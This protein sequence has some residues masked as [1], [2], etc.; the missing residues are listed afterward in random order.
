MSER[1]KILLVDDEQNILN[2]L[3]RSF[4]IK[5]YELFTAMNA[6]DALK[7]LEEQRIDLIVTDY[8]MPE[9]NG[10]ELLR[11]V[12]ELH[13]YTFRVILSGYVETEAIT[14]AI[15]EGIA[16]AYFKKPWSDYN[17]TDKISHIFETIDKIQ[18]RALF[19]IFNLIQ[20][21]PSLPGIYIE[22]EE[23][24]NSGAALKEVA[25]V[26]KNDISLTAKLL[27]I[28]N[29]VFY[30]AKDYASLEQV[31]LMIGMNSIKDIVL[32]YKLSESVSLDSES[33]KELASIFRYGL[34]LNKGVEHYF[35]KKINDLS[36]SVYSNI[37]LLST[38]GR[39]I[40]LTFFKDR[41]KKTLE[42]M[43]ENSVLFAEAEAELGYQK[44]LNNLI[45]S[46]FL[47]LNNMP[48]DVVSI[49]SGF[50][51]VENMPEEKREAGAVLNILSEAIDNL[52]QNGELTFSSGLDKIKYTDEERLESVLGFLREVSKV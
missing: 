12:R 49:I 1:K 3:R 50:N 43:N 41:Y 6:S 42:T 4:I 37:G 40:I 18:D 20:K 47:D 8:K 26:I 25:A 27:Q 5:D 10:I 2:A 28:G 48:F 17:L 31:I 35:S 44:E 34:L 38:I 36:N 22:L 15:G 30:G 13:P 11:K 19:D 24:I 23:L 32:V 29:S 21:L 33:Q 46:A 51:D 9:M 52:I 14:R 39:V 16:M 45:A 7:I